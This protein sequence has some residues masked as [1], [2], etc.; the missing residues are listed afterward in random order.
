MRVDGYKVLLNTISDGIQTTRGI[1][2]SDDL[3]T[4]LMINKINNLFPDV[5]ISGYL[6]PEFTTAENLVSKY[7]EFFSSQKLYRSVARST[8][9]E[10]FIDLL[11]KEIDFDFNIVAVGGAFEWVVE[12]KE[13][14]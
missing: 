1:F 3:T 6:C 14:S 8:K 4:N 9:Q 5:L 2:G 11:K 12:T 13:G 10:S 7:K